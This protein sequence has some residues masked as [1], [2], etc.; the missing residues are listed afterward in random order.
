MSRERRVFPNPLALV[1]AVGLALAACSDRAPVV[2][3]SP[4]DVG[5]PLFGVSDPANGGGACMGD[6]AAA[7]PFDDPG[8][9]VDGFKEDTDPESLVCEAEDVKV[10]ETHVT[11][12]F[13]P[14]LQQFVPFDPNDPPECDEGTN[15]RFKLNVDL[16]ETADSERQDIG[17]WIATDGGNA[18]TGACDHFNLP[19][20]TDG[21]TDV[22]G[23][24]CADIE[25][26]ATVEDFN[27]GELEVKCQSDPENPTSTKLLVG[28]CI[29]WKVPSD[30]QECSDDADGNGTNG[31]ASDFR[32]GTLPNNKA[33]CNCTPFEVDIVVRQTATI[34][35]IKECVPTTDPGTFDLKIDGTVEKDNAACGE[36]TGA[37]T[38][39]AGTNA[40]PGATH[41]VAEDGF[42]IDASNYTSV[43]ECTKNGDPYISETSGRGPF[44]V[45]VE[46]DDAVVCTF[47]NER[48]AQLTIVKQTNP[49]GSA[50]SFS[51]APTGFNGDASFSLSDGQSKSSGLVDAGTYTATETVP[52]GW[53][54]TSRACVFTGTQ[55]AKTFTSINNDAGVSVALGAGEDVTCTFTNTQRGSIV[56]IKDTQN[57]AT[58]PQDFA[59]TGTGTGMSGFSLDDDGDNAN[60]LS[61]TKTFSDLVPGGSRVVTETPLP[62]EWAL[63]AI[64]CSGA[65]NSTVNTSVAN[66]TATIGLAAGETVTCTYV[67]QRKARLTVDK[68][69]VGGG[70]LLFDFSLNPG[71]VSFSLA[72][73]T[74]PFTTG[75]S[76]APGT[77]RVCELNLAVSYS[78]TATVD[79]A[80]ATLINPDAS[81]V[82]P[83]DLGN[84]CV[85]VTVA[86][87]DDKTVVWTNTPPPGGDARTPGYWKNWASCAVS[88]GKQYQKAQ[89]KGLADKTLDANLPQTVGILTLAGGNPSPDCLKAVRLLNKSD[90]VSAKKKANDAAF[91]LASPLLA[92]LLNISADADPSCVGPFV[93][94]AQ[95]L[96]AGISFNGTGNYLTKNTSALYGQANFLAGKLD[97]Y[98][99]NV[100]VCT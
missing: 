53:D 13:D 59:Y 56:I 50:Q 7:L 1:A 19:V 79:G 23:D 93:T 18:E 62:S 55:N 46:P 25:E 49:D 32:A 47:T 39:G 21:T 61:N 40:D 4:A 37:V 14:D 22:D 75:F 24:E 29:S 30:D 86:Y 6:D 85:D 95:A 98:N 20:G 31:Q 72:D 70:T 2:G 66:R 82:P 28:S 54:L 100:L 94:Q 36:T 9:L 64:N 71:S 43:Y 51:F 63:T 60:T 91:N 45:E 58:D 35:V 12:Y 76:L 84:R 87:G 69:L 11:E 97:A 90:I 68:V 42:S 77:Y 83:E 89:Q 34:E 38:V 41:T 44:D 26:A 65:T 8:A 67:N 27:I 5:P 3:P 80:P 81:N 73:A 17:I 92:A 16:E 15:V 74:T 10:A 33:K 88:S 99:N 52:A 78:A 96:L 57:P 48:K